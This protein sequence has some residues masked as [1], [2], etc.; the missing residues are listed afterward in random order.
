[1]QN[2]ICKER[3]N[4]LVTT[5]YDWGIYTKSNGDD[6]SSIDTDTLFALLGESGS[7]LLVMI[8]TTP[9]DIEGLVQI[10]GGLP[11][12]VIRSKLRAM[13]AAG[14]VQEK[15]KENTFF[16]TDQGEIAFRSLIKLF[17]F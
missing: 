17:E 5:V 8:G 1:M 7:N 9:N 3:I 13:K 4:F 11:K 12:K 15:G 2:F 6:D 14:L 16:L 10:A